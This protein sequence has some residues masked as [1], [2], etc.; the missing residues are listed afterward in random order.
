MAKVT[1]DLSTAEL[2]YPQIAAW[3]PVLVG[4]LIGL[5]VLLH[6]EDG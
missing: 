6:L 5:L 1:N 3:L 4:G 2:L